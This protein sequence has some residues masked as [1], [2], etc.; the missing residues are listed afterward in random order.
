LGQE[1][2]DVVARR[3]EAGLGLLEVVIAITLFMIM[4]VPA[5]KFLV[6]G[7]R[8]TGQQRAKAIA[9]Q[10]AAQQP[11]G[12]SSTLE[13]ISGIQFKIASSTSPPSCKSIAT[14][15][16]GTPSIEVPMEKTTVTVTWGAGHSYTISRW[17]PSPSSFCPPPDPGAQP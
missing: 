13:T 8:V 9:T 6:G 17:K 14:T 10:L 16:S 3:E 7:V 2:S 1:T 11:S 4:L 12:A 5:A 15:T